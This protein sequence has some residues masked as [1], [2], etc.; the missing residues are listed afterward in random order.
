[1]TFKELQQEA[2]NIHIWKILFFS[3][4]SG[5]IATESETKCRCVSNSRNE[6]TRRLLPHLKT[7]NNKPS[8]ATGLQSMAPTILI[9]PHERA[10]R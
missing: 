5:S 9:S 8:L 7:F 4:A 1:M 2:L 10:F 6:F 3:T